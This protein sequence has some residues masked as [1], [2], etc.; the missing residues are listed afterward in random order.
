L[1]KFV[2]F[3]NKK[4]TNSL[5]FKEENPEKPKRTLLNENNM[6]EFEKDMYDFFIFPFVFMNISKAFKLGDQKIA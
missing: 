1:K 4:E 6:K 5:S 3:E 2:K